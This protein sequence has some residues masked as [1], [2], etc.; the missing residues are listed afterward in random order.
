MR[1]AI[2]GNLYYYKFSKSQLKDPYV[3]FANQIKKL[4]HHQ[5]EPVFVF[6]GRSPAPKQETVRIRHINRR[7]FEH[8]N[9]RHLFVFFKSL[10]VSCL[11]P[12]T[13]AD[14]YIGWLYHNNLIDFAITDDFDVLLFGCHRM[15]SVDKGILKEFR[16]RDILRDLAFTPRRFAY[17]CICMGTDYSCLRSSNTSDVTNIFINRR[18]AGDVKA[19]QEATGHDAARIQDVESVYALYRSPVETCMF[20][21]KKEHSMIQQSPTRLNVKTI[22]DAWD[23]CALKTRIP[24]STLAAIVRSMNDIRCT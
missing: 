20:D 21:K 14:M 17:M 8:I 4:L 11:R 9:F 16:M 7:K 2:D 15:I 5:I 13:E 1:V 3:G 10:N 19:M 18:E 23:Q 12:S 22:L 6:D 24:F